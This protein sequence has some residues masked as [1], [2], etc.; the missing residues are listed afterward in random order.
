MYPSDASG[1]EERKRMGAEQM[2]V[3]CLDRDREAYI[4]WVPPPP[5]PP[6]L[7][8]APADRAGSAGNQEVAGSIPGFSSS[9]SS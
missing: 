9:S 2:S 8:V 6:P 7:H 5:P 3:T 4:R 1:E